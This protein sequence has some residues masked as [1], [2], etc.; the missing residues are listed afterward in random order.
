MCASSAWRAA[1]PTRSDPIASLPMDDYRGYDAVGLAAL[2]R[3]GEVSAAELLAAA[4]DRAAEV[5]DRINAIVVEVEPLPARGGPFSGV[6]FLVKDLGQDLAG[7]R[8]S[9]GSRSLSP[10]PAPHTAPVVDRWL[11]AGLLVFRKTNA[12]EFGAKGITDP[13]L[14]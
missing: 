8:T 2:V 3:G 9:G 7:W 12:H 1:S 5:N 11:D 4:R 10:T 13:E 14:F 6:P